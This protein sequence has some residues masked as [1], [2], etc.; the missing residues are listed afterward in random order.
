MK[1]LGIVLMA[2]LAIGCGKEELIPS[3]P[4]EMSSMAG[5]PKLEWGIHRQTWVESKERNPWSDDDGGDITCV[6]PAADCYDDIV[7]TPLLGQPNAW[8]EFLNY[9]NA[10][11]VHA[12]FSN[13]DWKKLFPGLSSRPLDLADLKSGSTT[14]TI[15]RYTSA[16]SIH[17]C[18][19]HK[20]GI[21]LTKFDAAKD[22]I[23]ASPIKIK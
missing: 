8:D 16:D 21:D 6:P 11:R 15:S 4:D 12:Y 19:A 13:E 17:L 18:I 2:T 5:A 10:S 1:K 20:S 9:Y 3:N 23:F 14:I 7:V 22:V